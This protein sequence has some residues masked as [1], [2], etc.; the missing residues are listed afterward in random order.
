MEANFN[1]LNSN[2]VLSVGDHVLQ[3]GQLIEE[4]IKNFEPK[5]NDLKFNSNNLLLKKICKKVTLHG[6]FNR[7][8]WRFA[9]MG[10]KCKCLSLGENN[11]QQGDLKIKVTLDFLTL[12]RHISHTA[13]GNQSNLSSA[14]HQ[15]NSNNF[16][17]KASLEFCP[18]DED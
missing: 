9:P 2:D 14:K 1:Y 18:E 3:A 15:Q 12:G 4:L 13:A 8:E 6:T 5:S 7:L 16:Q 11:W 10:I 17:M